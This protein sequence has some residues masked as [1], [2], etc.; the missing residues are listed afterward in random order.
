MESGR[1]PTSGP[2]PHNDPQVRH[3]APQE[4][5]GSEACESTE[6]DRCPVLLAEIWPRPHGDRH[7]ADQEARGRP[8]LAVLPVQADPG[9]LIQALLHVAIPAKR[10][11]RPGGKGDQAPQAKVENGRAFRRREVQRGNP[12]VLAATDLGRMVRPPGRTR[13]ARCRRRNQSA[14]V[15][16]GTTGAV[17]GDYHQRPA[18]G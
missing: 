9:A 3:A 4:C 6:T 12:R 14:G 18:L 13:R 17:A 8:V 11:V 16:V 15:T 2:S 10:D 7:E 1:R 5:H